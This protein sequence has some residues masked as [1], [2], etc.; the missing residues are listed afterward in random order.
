MTKSSPN[1]LQKIARKAIREIINEV[2]TQKKSKL[3]KTVNAKSEIRSP[4]YKTN[5]RKQ[6]RSRYIPASVRVSV[7]NRD[8]Y[9]CVFCGRSSRQVSLEVD[10]IILFL[11]L[12]AGVMTL[13]TYKLYVL[14]VTEAKVRDNSIKF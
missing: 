12:K 3:I 4:K 7:L 1:L 6:T 8:N 9:K 2:N 14:T 5:K 13:I 11:F 10:Q